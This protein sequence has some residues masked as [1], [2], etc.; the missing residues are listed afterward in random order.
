MAEEF[1]TSVGAL[2][3]DWTN[4][5]PS[6]NR[7]ATLANRV[8]ADIEHLLA[9]PTIVTVSELSSAR[10]G[11]LFNTGPLTNY[12]TTLFKVGRDFLQTLWD[13]DTFALAYA[14]HG[15]TFQSVPGRYLGVLLEHIDTGTRVLH[16]SL[17]LPHKSGKEEGTLVCGICVSVYARACVIASCGVRF[18]FHI[19]L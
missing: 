19:Q 9:R 15:D 11:H 5:H 4:R 3:L 2:N 12:D 10:T 14:G 1:A 7:P 13:S 6:I 16:F 18:L 17:H 8:R